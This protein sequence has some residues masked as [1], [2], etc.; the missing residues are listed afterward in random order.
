MVSAPYFAAPI[1]REPSTT[2]RCGVGPFWRSTRPKIQMKMVRRGCPLSKK[3]VFLRGFPEWI[4]CMAGHIWTYETCQDENGV[5]PL[6]DQTRRKWADTLMVLHLQ[7]VKNFW[8]FC[9]W[10]RG[11]DAERHFW[12]MI[13]ILM[14]PKSHP[15][16]LL[17]P[18]YQAEN[19]G[20]QT[21]ACW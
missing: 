15:P 9:A 20:Q 16:S 1:L 8:L 3:W 10:W 7:N 12:P 18:K 6:S 11:Q 19:L 5:D 13:P 17:F 21:G 4:R 2:A 14:K